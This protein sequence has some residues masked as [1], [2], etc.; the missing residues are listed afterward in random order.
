M[1]T[2]E[3]INSLSEFQRN[4]R[5]HIRKLKKSGRATVLTVNGKA[6]VVVQDAEAYSRLLQFAEG[7]EEYKAVREGIRD[8]EAGRL[9]PAE[10]VFK[11]LRAQYGRKRP[12]RRSA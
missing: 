11:E 2:P 10:K 3:D 6:A 1:F 8:M 7:L 12:R 5:T 9:I 4:A